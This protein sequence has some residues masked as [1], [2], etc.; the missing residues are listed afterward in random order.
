MALTLDA[1]C[2]KR[3]RGE[4]WRLALKKGR[5]ELSS[6]ARRCPRGQTGSIVPLPESLPSA[7]AR[8]SP[9]RGVQEQPKSSGRSHAPLSPALGSH[10]LLGG[11]GRWLA[12][13]LTGCPPSGVSQPSGS[14]WGRGGGAQP[15]LTVSVFVVDPVDPAVRQDL[16]V[17]ADAD[18]AV[19]APQPLDAQQIV[20]V[21]AEQIP[22]PGGQPGHGAREESLP[23]PLQGLVVLLGEDGHAAARQPG[24][25][26]SQE[27]GWP[28]GRTGTS[29][30][31]RTRAAHV[32]PG[33]ASS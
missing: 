25:Q 6:S 1:D 15:L 22:L 13:W 27:Q 8:S 2:L 18:V 16:D 11:G 32:V 4:V 3:G 20:P 33:E 31:Q 23:A 24:R 21:P 9:S 26:Q 12:G 14:R 30:P 5:G 10:A 17:K 28:A 7:A 29:H 19:E